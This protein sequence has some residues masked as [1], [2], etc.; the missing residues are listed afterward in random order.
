[1]NDFDR[2]EMKRDLEKA[3]FYYDEDTL[4]TRC[5]E[6]EALSDNDLCE[7]CLDF[8]KH[9]NTDWFHAEETY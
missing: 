7:Y 4:C 8:I 2:A 9:N 3:V 1:M 6:E 5:C